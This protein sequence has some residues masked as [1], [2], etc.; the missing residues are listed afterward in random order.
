M[1]DCRRWRAAE[2]GTQEATSRDG[3]FG[4]C[5]AMLKSIA[6]SKKI[7]YLSGWWFGTFFPYYMG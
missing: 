6:I 7:E 5:L 2:V 3:G 4:F 1:M